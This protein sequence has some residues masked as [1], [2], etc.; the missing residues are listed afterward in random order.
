VHA[1]RTRH[2]VAGTVIG[3]GTVSNRD[4]GVGSSCLAE[5]RMLEV[6]ADGTPHTEFLRFGDT[7]EID[8]C[9]PDGRSLFGAIRQQVRRYVPT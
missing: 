2:L 5:R 3:S 1:A 9:D 7:V 8:M 6:L 4:P